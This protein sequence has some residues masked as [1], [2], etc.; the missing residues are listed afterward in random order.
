[1]LFD[2]SPLV[3]ESMAIWPG[4]VVPHREVHADFRHGERVSLSAWRSS[5]HVGAHVDAPSHVKESGAAIDQL[6]LDTFVGPA[7]VIALHLPPQTAIEPEHL[8]ARLAA[9]RVLLATGSFNYTKPFD[10]RFIGLSAAAVDYLH[11]RGVLL[12]GI[13]TPSVDLFTATDLP[14]HEALARHEMLVLEGL[15]LSGVP[16]GL[17]ELVALPLRLAGFEASPVR[18]VLRR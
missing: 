12:V 2:I 3:T 16:E 8:P 7:Q 6:P 14:A 15:D 17:Y 1:M 5:V 11:E 10:T 18:A 4:D 13:D 9:P